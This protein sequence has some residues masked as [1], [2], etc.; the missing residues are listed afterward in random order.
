MKF[1]KVSSM[2]IGQYGYDPVS[3]SHFVRCGFSRLSNAYRMYD[4]IRG[5]YVFMDGFALLYVIKG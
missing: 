3:M 5:C 4:V 1:E 2:K